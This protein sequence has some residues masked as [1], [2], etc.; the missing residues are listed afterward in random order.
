M[1][2]GKKLSG[3]IYSSDATPEIAP[4]ILFDEELEN[5]ICYLAIDRAYKSLTLKIHPF[6]EA[7]LN[8]GLFSIKEFS[9]FSDISVVLR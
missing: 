8:K 9:C 1:P 4:S 3:Y 6:V 5:H 2:D 7:F